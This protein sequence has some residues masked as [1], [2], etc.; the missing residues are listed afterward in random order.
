MTKKLTWFN[1]LT[2]EEW[3]LNEMPII[4]YMLFVNGECVATGDVALSS[5]Q[6]E[7]ARV[8]TKYTINAAKTYLDRQA[9]EEWLREQN[10]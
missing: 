9:F 10:P 7:Q 1:P 2:E 6:N 8:E 4:E 5:W 3:Q